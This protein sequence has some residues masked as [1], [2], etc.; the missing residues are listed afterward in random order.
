M[1]SVGKMIWKHCHTLCHNIGRQRRRVVKT[2][3]EWA[4]LQGKADELDAAM[5]VVQ[6]PQV[7]VDVNVQPLK[8]RGVVWRQH[9]CC[10]ALE[11]LSS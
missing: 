3:D 1:R 10:C 11:S 8:S 2:M 9:V 4:E 7:G 5:F 6:G